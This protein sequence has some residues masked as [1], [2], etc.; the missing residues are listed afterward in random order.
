MTRVM[1]SVEITPEEDGDCRECEFYGDATCPLLEERVEEAGQEGVFTY[2]ERGP[3]CL[4]AEKLLRDVVGAGE[5]M[6]TAPDGSDAAIA[7]YEAWDY[8]AAALKGTP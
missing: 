4:A 3:R 6:R 7:A 5:A 2:W 8:A 1:I